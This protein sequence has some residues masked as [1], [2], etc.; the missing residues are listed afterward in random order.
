MVAKVPGELIASR[1]ERTFHNEH[2]HT[3]LPLGSAA[4]SGLNADD[5]EP[6]VN[7]RYRLEKTRR[8]PAAVFVTRWPQAGRSVCPLRSEEHTSE[9]QSLMRI[10]YAVFGWKKKN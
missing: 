2:S 1:V 9:L 7:G 5:I 8:K 4:C 3:D 6:L 10:S